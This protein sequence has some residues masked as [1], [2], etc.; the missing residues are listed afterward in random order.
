MATEGA[1]EGASSW[2]TAVKQIVCVRLNNWP[3]DWLRRKLRSE[4]RNASDTSRHDGREATERRSDGATEGKTK[5]TR[6]VLSLRRSVASSLRRSPPLVI[7]HTVAERQVIVA[8]SDEAFDLGIREGMTL[9]Q[10]RAL[11]AGVAH[12]E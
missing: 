4:A 2:S 8:A 9:T 5:T 3:I 11:H 10:A 12:A 7:V 6:D 1:S